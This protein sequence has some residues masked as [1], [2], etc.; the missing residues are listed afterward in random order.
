[1]YKDNWIQRQR[2]GLLIPL[3]VAQWRAKQIGPIEHGT[4]VFL[5]PR[6]QSAASLPILA[7][8]KNWRRKIT[9]D[10]AFSIFYNFSNMMIC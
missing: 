10:F 4:C 1:M 3:K 8:S 5:K 6:L 9:L 7:D 2:R